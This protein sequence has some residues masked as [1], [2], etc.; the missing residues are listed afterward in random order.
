MCENK[1]IVAGAALSLVL[2]LLLLGLFFRGNI[3]H[4]VEP[5]S[6][7]PS[8]EL[9]IEISAAGDSLKKPQAPAETKQSPPETIAETVEPAEP[10]LSVPEKTVAADSSKAA[11]EI[12]Q[13][14]P[15]AALNRSVAAALKGQRPDFSRPFVKDAITR[16][17]K[18]GGISDKMWGLNP[19]VLEKLQQARAD[20]KA[21][22]QHKADL[23][24]LA[25]HNFSLS[26][27]SASSLSGSGVRYERMGNG[28][29]VHGFFRM[30]GAGIEECW[31]TVVQPD[32]KE[33]RKQVDCALL[34]PL[35]G[36][37]LA[38][39]YIH[40]SLRTPEEKR[41]YRTLKK[42]TLDQQFIDKLTREL[43]PL[44]NLPKAK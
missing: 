2:H 19:R 33:V 9:Q 34:K 30:F 11:A 29:V 39:T 18:T 12:P 43:L 15:T 22:D 42:K 20:R 13:T 16:D 7:Q 25:M 27:K 26:G 8:K 40:P 14:E 21:R 10:P 3:L 6:R 35:D 24:K 37:E 38:Q 5:S 28:E 36:G 4:P 1:T 31:R 23:E 32:G 17:P 41:K 44:L